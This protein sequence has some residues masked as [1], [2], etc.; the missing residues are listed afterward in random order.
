MNRTRGKT[1]VVNKL[2]LQKELPRSVHDCDKNGFLIGIAQMN[3]AAKK[4]AP[5]SLWS[6]V[7]YHFQ[8]LRLAGHDRKA[9]LYD[10]LR[11]EYYWSH[12]TSYVYTTERVVAS[13]SKTYQYIN[14]DAPY[15]YFWRVA[16][17][18]FVL[19]NIPRPLKT[20]INHKIVRTVNDEP[21]L[22]L[23]KSLK[24]IKYKHMAY[25]LPLYWYLDNL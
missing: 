15:N 14:V 11:R 9:R 24:G 19:M 3:G 17:R 10:N 7:P 25:C 6:H 16:P 20:K 8:Y 21:L 4:L 2:P 5:T 1:F 22:E 13:G 18:R 12:V 23:N